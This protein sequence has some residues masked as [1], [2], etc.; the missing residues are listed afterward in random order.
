MSSKVP[1]PQGTVRSRASQY[2][3]CSCVPKGLPTHTV[4][5]D[6]HVTCTRQSLPILEDSFHGKISAACSSLLYAVPRV[7]FRRAMAAAR[8]LF[9]LKI[10]KFL[11]G[12]LRILS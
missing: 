5:R 4:H 12:V 3:A 11:L 7:A 9:D 2:L 6:L 1:S 8:E 10:L